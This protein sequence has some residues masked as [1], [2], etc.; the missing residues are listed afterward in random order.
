MMKLPRFK[1]MPVHYE[2]FHNIRAMNKQDRLKNRA[3]E[4]Y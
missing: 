4:I 3:T 2:L 1:N